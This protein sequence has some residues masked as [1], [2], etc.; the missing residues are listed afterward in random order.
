MGW[1]KPL[2]GGRPVT[3]P[4]AKQQARRHVP[5]GPLR[6]VRKPARGGRARPHDP[7]REEA[8]MRKALSGRVRRRWLTAGVAAVAGTALAAVSLPRL[9]GRTAPTVEPA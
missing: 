4:F 8:T 5:E 1:R 3:Y 2:T 9:P 7:S 6:T